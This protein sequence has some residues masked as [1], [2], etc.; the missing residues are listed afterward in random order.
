MLCMAACTSSFVDDTPRPM[1]AMC[2][3]MSC[4]GVALT[5][6]VCVE[7]MLFEDNVQI[8]DIGRRKYRQV[9]PEGTAPIQIATPSREVVQSATYKSGKAD[10]QDLHSHDKADNGDAI[11]PQEL[12]EGCV[13]EQCGGCF[14][15]FTFIIF[16]FCLKQVAVLI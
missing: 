12:P 3:R 8:L 16:F 6:C 2:S 15:C 1:Y 5:V 13:I 10:N 14:S 11:A 7:V 9:L 4:F